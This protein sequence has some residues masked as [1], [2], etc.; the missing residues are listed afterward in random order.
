MGAS[1]KL[2][3]IFNLICL[4]ILVLIVLYIIFRLTETLYSR[5]FGDKRLVSDENIVN[6][7][8]ESIDKYYNYI[9]FGQ[10]EKAKHSTSFFSRKS[11]FDY[12]KIQKEIESYGEF[13]VVVKYA[14]K[15]YGETYRCYV[16]TY[17]KMKE[18][19]SYIVNSDKEKMNEIIISLDK[20]N[21][22]FSV[23]YDEY[24]GI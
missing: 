13:V 9:Y 6:E 24:Q 14:Y 7:L 8:Q 15:L 2:S 11:N 17:D 19:L 20:Y 3:L 16:V 21:D 4:I 22:N 12:E 5:P 18:D 10:F 1:R 23:V